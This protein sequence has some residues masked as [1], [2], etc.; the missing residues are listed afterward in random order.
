MRRVTLDFE[1]LSACDLKKCGAYKYSL[2]PTTKPTCLA[3][4]ERGQKRIYLLRFEMINRMWKDL[5]VDFRNLW[6]SF[7]ADP[8]LLFIAQ[9]AFF[10]T[11]IYKNIL[12]KRYGWPDIPFTRFRCT[13]AKAAAC[14]L[15]RSL[16]GAGAA[17]NLTTQK[18]KR[19]YAAMMATCKPTKQW[20]AWR[21]ACEDVKAGKKVGPKKRS[22]FEGKEPPMFLTPEAAPDVWEVL[23]RYCK[24]DVKTE[25]L[26]DETLPDLTPSEQQV[27]FLNQKINWRGFKVDVSAA[28]KIVDIMAI[29]S[30]KKLKE[31]DIIT[32]GLVTKAG[33]R[34]SILEFL[35]LDGIELPDIRAK[36]VEDILEGGELNP[37]MR[38]LL[39]IRQALS[40]TSTKKYQGFIDRAGKD[41]RVRDILLYHG[42][43]TGRDSGTGIQPHNFPRG[44]IEIDPNRPYAPVDNIIQNDMEW[45]KLLYGDNLS[46]VFSSIL[47]NMILPG[48]GK[49]LFVADFS[50]I[51]VAV[52]WWLA[53]NKPGLEILNSGRDPYIYMASLN[54][55]KSYKKIERA[56]K[57][58]E[59]WALN[60]RQ[61]GKAQI[62]GCGF[63]MGWEKFLTTAYDQYR[64][65]LTKKQSKVAVKSYREQN[66]AVPALW[67]QY[68]M[69]AVAAIEEKG[70]TFQ[71][72]K[73]K[74]FR[75][76]GFLWVELPSGRRLAY[77]KPRIVW[78]VREYDKVVLDKKGNPKLDKNGD[79]VTE[80]AYT[81]P[82]KSIEFLGLSKSKK[83]LVPERTWGGTLTEN[84]VQAIARDLMKNGEAELENA[85]YQVLLSVHDEL[86][87][88]KDKGK[89]TVEEFKALMCTRPLWADQHLPIQAEG[90]KGPRYRK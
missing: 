19:G 70:K 21:K 84:I 41:Q 16:E 28:Q 62:L 17:L 86:L 55:G 80:K 24:V 29:E 42:A 9:N 63:G 64:L 44:V 68:E 56:V 76:K 66:E 22:L 3:F 26:L 31:L 51:E 71:A 2:D 73:C 10:E 72:G 69:G 83:E 78:A 27:W 57:N 8:T 74:F 75:E 34:Q 81:R 13:A 38:R 61:L 59:K 50:K 43:S 4:K 48:D 23:Y 79:E 65:E 40:R 15:P 45:L 52:L 33:A 60:A 36:T 30:K 90:W 18:D 14:A 49:E 87:S 35:A 47:R 7:I 5:P 25:E 37:D 54:T 82:Q 1:T 6:L 20:N 46:M 89:G 53:D 88:D 77:R 85:G 58:G 12:V 11:V 39:E 32:M 67:K